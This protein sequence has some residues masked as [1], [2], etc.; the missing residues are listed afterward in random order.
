MA[1][2]LVVRE[3]IWQ[4]V[5]IERERRRSLYSLHFFFADDVDN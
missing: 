3:N 4:N 1:G 5:Y 2:L